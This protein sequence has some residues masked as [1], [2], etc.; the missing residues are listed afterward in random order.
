MRRNKGFT[1]VEV[2]LVV[3]IVGVLSALAMPSFVSSRERARRN[4]CLK[5]LRS[6]D[7]A[8]SMW[9]VYE[10]HTAE[11]TPV[12]DDIVPTYIKDVPS[13]P[14]GGTYTLQTVDVNPTCSVQGH[15]LS[16]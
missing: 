16:E 3:A 9:A 6:I 2:M 4:L 5:N 7:E 13:C 12:W 15:V 11:E 10:G 14:A 1:L 8:K